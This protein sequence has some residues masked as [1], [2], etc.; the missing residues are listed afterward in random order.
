MLPLVYVIGLGSLV[1]D[2]LVIV[3]I[4]QANE[5]GLGILGIFCPLFTFI[6]GWVKST[7]WKIRPIMLVWSCLIVINIILQIVLVQQQVLVQH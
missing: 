2:I 3:K 7:Q 1:C 5:I 4:F 6:Y